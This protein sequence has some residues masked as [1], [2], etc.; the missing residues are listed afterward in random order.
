MFYAFDNSTQSISSLKKENS[1]FFL[2]DLLQLQLQ[3]L[4]M[5]WFLTLTVHETRNIKC[6]SWNIKSCSLVWTV[7]CGW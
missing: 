3:L 4:E 7:M 5:Q 6:W 1:R 2:Q